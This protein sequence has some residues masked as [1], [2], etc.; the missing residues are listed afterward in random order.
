M[1]NGSYEMFDEY[2]KHNLTFIWNNRQGK[3][4]EE[5]KERQKAWRR[6]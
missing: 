3:V 1:Y 4:E 6:G 2:D 5:E